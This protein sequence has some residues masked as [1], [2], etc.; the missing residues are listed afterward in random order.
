VKN[1][2]IAMAWVLFCT[3]FIAGA[4]AGIQ[5][6]AIMK[7]ESWVSP[8]WGYSTPKITT[9]GTSWFTVGMRGNKTD[10]C[11]GLVCQR[12]VS[13]VWCEI[14]VLSGI[15]QPPTVCLD[16]VKRLIVVYAR[17]EKP[18][19]ILRAISAA[20]PEKMDELPSPP[21][22]KNA[23]YIG[24]TCWRDTLYLAYITSPDYGMWLATLD[25]TTLKWTPSVI[26]QAG[27]TASK[28]KTAWVYPILM[29][30]EKGLHLVA[31]NAPDGGEGNTY[32]EIWYL[33]FPVGMSE[34]DIR[35]PVQ[36]V[37]T[38]HV[39]YAMD[40]QVDAA[41]RVHILH[42]GNRRIYGP[43]LKDDAEASGIFHSW[44]NPDSGLWRTSRVGPEGIGSLFMASK[45]MEAF[46]AGNGVIGRYEWDESSGKWTLLEKDW[47]QGKVAGNPGFMDVVSAAS[48]ARTD[49]PALVLDVGDPANPNAHSLYA[50]RS[51]GE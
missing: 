14:A 33:H 3:P 26:L 36:S 7:S 25:L 43:P 31:S 12:D 1:A 49:L 9:D 50:V 27:Q 30:S 19:R 41:G 45:K 22:M 6:E 47:L 2:H 11:A 51:A 28:P 21:D 24:I 39:A 18:V 10:D 46:L 40:M 34:P 8:Y 42:Q 20:Q 4:E 37:P 48:G 23:Y 15:Y 32:N 5:V 13:G 44:R 35:E 16:S 17:A 38:G 29:G